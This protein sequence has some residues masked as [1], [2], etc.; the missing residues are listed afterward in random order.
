MEAERAACSNPKAE[1][2]RFGVK[3]GAGGAKVETAGVTDA[4]VDQPA[5]ARILLLPLLFLY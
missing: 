1:T 3:G 5:P 2:E 4:E